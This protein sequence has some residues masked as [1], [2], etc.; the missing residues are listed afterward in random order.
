MIG[1]G[2]GPLAAAKSKLGGDPPAVVL[3]GSLS[4]LSVARSLSAAGIPTYVLDRESSPA[5]VSRAVTEF[6]AVGADRP[7]EHMLEWLYAADFE[8]V[9]LP[10]SDDGVELVARHRAD[11]VAHGHHPVEGSDEV[12]LAMLNKVQ[13]YDLARRHGIAAPR[14]VRLVDEQGLDTALEQLDF[15]CVLKPDQSHLFARRGGGGAKVLVVND[16]F[17][18]RREFARFSA[19]GVE[20]F[21]TEVIYGQTD[22][23]VSYYGYLDED[24]ETLVSFTKRKIRQ[25]PPG[26]G[27]GT[28]HE[29]TR[30]PEVAAAGLRFLQAVGLRGLGN[31]EFK[32]GA[33]D[34]KLILIECNPR[35]T[36]SNELARR[37][38]V[39]LACLSYNRALHRPAAPIE[40]YRVGLHLWDPARDIGALPAYRRQGELST[41]AWC[42]SLMHRQV[43]PAFRLDDPAPALARAA[44]MIRGAGSSSPSRAAAPSTGA[45]PGRIPASE[46]A[47]ADPALV[48]RALDRMADGGGRRGRAI[49]AR[50]DLTRASGIGP[51]VRRVRSERR[52]SGLGPAARDRLYDD[53]WARAAAR[54]GAKVVPLAPGLLELHANDARTRVYH[55]FVALDDPVTLQVAL[56][57]VVVHGLMQDA[58]VPH[59]EYLEWN[60]AD[61]GPAAS[62]LASCGGPCVVKPAA[63]TGGGHGVVPG[64]NDLNDLVRARW[65]A[66]TGV[67]RLLIERQIEGAIYRLLLLD[68]ELLDVVRS[69]P[70]N[71]TGD[72]HS[73]IEALIARENERRV[74]AGGW[75]GL[76]LIGLN[77]DTML[78]LRRAGL[79]LSSVL[80]EGQYLP[81]RIATN[82]NAAR[83]N[84]TW[85]E[86]V[87]PSVVEDARAAVEAVG[88][89]LA[90]VDVVTRDISRPLI[91]TGGVVSEVNGGPGLHHHYL[92]ADLEKATPVAVFVLEKLL[93]GVGHDAVLAEHR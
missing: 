67:D 53:I 54:C 87:S 55:Q 20:M 35:F 75:A 80:P 22:E 59:A 16:A 56:D 82:C 19:L 6:V 77:L 65:H 48:D 81:L 58:G 43:L 24:G 93:A 89:R 9:V 49:A 31:I 40:S 85:E 62:F 17:Q 46:S 12:L 29:T 7:Q 21:V 72:G 18:L 84:M 26:F 44:S 1:R 68:G 88:L 30:D 28:Y 36:L 91:E 92:V 3:G 64:V 50:L 47:S 63:G 11:L 52:F 23:F 60:V 57:K 39:D 41:L 76:S 83:D 5:R 71:V 66:S 73:T 70:A 74:E 2:R 13:T 33:Q 38:G 69:V 51:L 79:T 34:G 15:P 4:A 90:G 27:I 42:G 37:A 32:R 78:T 10:A 25:C 8:T 14:I 45:A 86:E 61:L